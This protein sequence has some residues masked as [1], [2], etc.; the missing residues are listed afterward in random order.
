MQIIG[1]LVFVVSIVNTKYFIPKA[2]NWC[3]LHPSEL[4]KPQNVMLKQ[5]QP[6]LNQQNTKVTQ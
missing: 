3:I 5:I 4:A 1:I 6:K 2:T